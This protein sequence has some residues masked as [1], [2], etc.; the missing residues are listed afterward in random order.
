[1]CI[2]GGDDKKCN[3][4]C[5]FNEESAI[6]DICTIYDTCKF[7]RDPYLDKFL[8]VVMKLKLLSHMKIIYA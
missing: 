2:A 4:V 6:Y 5:Q 7:V 8:R 1:M 3:G